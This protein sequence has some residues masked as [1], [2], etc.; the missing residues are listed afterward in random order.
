MSGGNESSVARAGAGAAQ[1][2]KI[3]AASIAARFF[4]IIDAAFRCGLLVLKSSVH[5]KDQVYK[6]I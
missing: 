3:N 2:N 4:A 5:Y 1:R 6:I